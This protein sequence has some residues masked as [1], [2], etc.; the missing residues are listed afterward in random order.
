MKPEINTYNKKQETSKTE[1]GSNRRM[2]TKLC[3]QNK[4]EYYNNK[5]RDIK[6]I[7]KN[8]VWAYRKFYKGANPKDLEL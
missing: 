4:G 5:V 3:T 2:A 7:N 1:Y 6:E 8:C